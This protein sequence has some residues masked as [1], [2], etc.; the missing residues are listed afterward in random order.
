MRR[1]LSCIAVLLAVLPGACSGGGD[2][3]DANLRV[4]LTDAP[5]M[6]MRSVNVTV[7][8]VRIHQSA[9]AGAD[10]AGWRDLPVT[11]PMPVDLMRIRGVLYE[12]CSAS[13]D[14]GHYQQVRLVVRQNAGTMPPYQNS[15]TTMDGAVHPVD[16]PGE[17]KIVH[18]FTVATGTTTDLTL[19]FIAEQS[20][21]QRGN[22]EYYMQPVIHPSS[23]MH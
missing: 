6:G 13:L 11:A 1:I 7:T 5:M 21:H 17:I 15:A 12:L 4:N 18:S 14:A 3:G 9:D 22:G 23:T 16:M 10:A 20:V 8:N 2:G 19:D